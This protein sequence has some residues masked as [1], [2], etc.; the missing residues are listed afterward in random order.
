MY[1]LKLRFVI[2]AGLLCF[3]LPGS[4][5]ADTT[6]T[7]TGNSLS[8]SYGTF[9]VTITLDTT[10][11]GAALQSLPANTDIS[12]DLGPSFAINPNGWPNQD[13]LGF[14][15]GGPFGSNYYKMTGSPVVLIGTDSLG[16]ITSWNITQTLFASYPAVSGEDPNDFYATYTISST[17]AGDQGTLIT[18]QDAGLAPPSTSLVSAGTWSPAVVPEPSSFVLAGSGLL[19]LLGLRRRLRH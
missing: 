2:L 17:T 15:L 18:D 14:P 19:V 7:Y 4:L 3:I 11:M 1:Y 12:L 16:N 5:W 8:T 13:Q 9:Q 6:Y 10:L